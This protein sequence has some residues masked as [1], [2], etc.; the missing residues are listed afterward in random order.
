MY[1]NVLAFQNVGNMCYLN[2]ALQCLLCIPKFRYYL[3]YIIPEKS[4]KF[5][6]DE[7]IRVFIDLCTQYDNPNVFLANPITIKQI[8]GRYDSFFRNHMQQ[9][10][11]ECLIRVIDILHEKT[12]CNEIGFPV[13]DSVSAKAWG[14][15][16]KLFG[17]SFITDLFGGQLKSTLVC[18]VCKKGRDSFEAMNDMSIPMVDPK[19]SKND[20]ID[21]VDCFRS[22]FASEHLDDLLTCDHCKTK[23]PTLKY[24]KMWVFPEILILHL[25][26]SRATKSNAI[27]DFSENLIFRASHQENKHVRYKLKCIV[28][29]FG[30]TPN[31]GH[32][33]CTLVSNNKWVNIDDSSI[34]IAEK[35]TLF[36]SSS[37]YLFM[38]E[39]VI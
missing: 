23:T 31:S 13:G 4:V 1:K 19:E 8:L 38:Y 9:D 28:N 37:S 29:H 20:V 22:F 10:S 34:Y 18:Q 35:K 7:L 14:N 36:T 32:Y 6:N 5:V 30:S 17:R 21:I 27:V 2:S 12:K 25:K 3:Q 39:K 15:Y 16:I 26:R 33:S 11:H 24:I